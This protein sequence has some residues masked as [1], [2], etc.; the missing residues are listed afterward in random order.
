MSCKN[1]WKDMWISKNEKDLRKE[2]A[3]LNNTIETMNTE[4]KSLSNVISDKD[5]EI[6]ELSRSISMCSKEDRKSIDFMSS[7]NEQITDFL[8]NEMKV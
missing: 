4:I 5:D 7:V 8:K 2:V 1:F 3:M 6:S